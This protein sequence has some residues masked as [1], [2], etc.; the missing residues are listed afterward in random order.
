VLA[1][2]V[3]KVPSEDFIRRLKKAARVGMS[4]YM[5]PMEW[6][7]LDALPRTPSAK[8]DYPALAKQFK[9]GGNP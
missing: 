2:V 9:N 5:Q 6:Y 8:I 4:Q 7:V 3:P 1:A